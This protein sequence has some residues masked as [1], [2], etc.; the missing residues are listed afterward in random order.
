MAASGLGVVDD[1]DF[2]MKEGQHKGSGIIFGRG[3]G[4]TPRFRW[5]ELFQKDDPA[6]LHKVVFS[7]SDAVNM[8]REAGV[9]SG[10]GVLFWCMRGQRRAAGGAAAYVLF[11]NPTLPLSTVLFNM[12][13]IRPGID[14]DARWKGRTLLDFLSQFKQYLMERSVLPAIRTT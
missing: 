7:L 8:M 9:E 10:F 4:I 5:T 2:K 3:V 6:R 1:F 12:Q 11:S 14:F 13:R